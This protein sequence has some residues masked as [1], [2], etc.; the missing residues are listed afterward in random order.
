MNGNSNDR[1]AAIVSAVDSLRPVIEDIA[2]SL[3]KRPETGLNEVFASEKLRGILSDNGFSVEAGVA[4]LPTSFVARVGK[5]RPNIAF[6][7]EYDALPGI[8]HGCG[9][10]LMAAV[11]VGAGLA[12]SRV[13]PPD[14]LGASWTVLGTP[15]EET[16]GGKVVMV[17]KGVFEDI[18]AA[19]IAHP[20]QRNG[21]GGGVRWA[22]HPLEITFHGRTS[23][24]GGNPEGGINALDAC[25]AAYISI[26][27][28]R[29]HLKDPVRIAGIIAHGGHAQNIV[30]DLA[31][32]RFTLRSTDWRYLE[33]VIIPKVKQ[34]AEGAAQA[35]GCTVEFR[36]HEMLFRDTL[37]YPVLQ[38][39]CSKNFAYVGAEL[40]PRD[41]G[42][43]G[44]GVTDVGSVTWVTPAI[45]IGFNS[46]S[47]RGH[48]VEMADSTVTPRGIDAAVMAAKVLALSAYDIVVEPHLLAEAKAYLKERLS[49]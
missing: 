21:V 26:R 35:V 40:P 12:M 24:A 37:D 41:E 34:C 27:N 45:Q 19:F 38:E 28:L 17:E 36:H 2:V 20:G 25:V 32:M 15:A 23:H 31:Q 30:P 22:S 48:S 1:K 49:S 46:T 42:Y 14:E 7:A 13:C 10:N 16:I 43:A 8:G 4:D 33:N 39:V 3:Y 29:N 47:A 18:D 9:H 6:M 11:A 44:G 5:K